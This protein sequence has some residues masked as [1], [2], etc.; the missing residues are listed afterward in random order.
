MALLR[1]SPIVSFLAGVAVLALLGFGIYRV[2][3]RVS[4]I[5]SDSATGG[6]DSD[7]FYRAD[8][9][10][11]AVK[12]VR[13]EI[14]AGGDV[15]ELR[16]EAKR[17]KFTVRE[18]KSEDATGFA[19]RAG[20]PSSLSDFGVDVVGHGTLADQSIPISDLA[21]TALTRM[22]V[23]ARKRDPAAKLDTIHF[24]TLQ[25]DPGDPDP[26]WRMNVHGRLYLANLDGRGFH[27][28]GEGAG[29]LADPELSPI[30]RNALKLSHCISGAQGDVDKIQRCQRQYLK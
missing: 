11:T 29:T 27:S 12:A 24:F 5:G 1:R 30:E 20:D 9:F 4:K 16:I 28:T 25:I 13:G 8:N 2:V 10:G 26:V 3:H 14:G 23:Q 22:E 18:G 21:A 6:A 19:A 17:A 7:S 15:L